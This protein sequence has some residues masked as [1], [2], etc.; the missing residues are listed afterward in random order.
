N[1]LRY[2]LSMQV[3]TLENWAKDREEEV[4]LLS[5]FPV[6]K[7]LDYEVMAARF[8]YFDHYYDQLN[9]IVYIDSDGYIR[10][11][12]GLDDTTVFYEPLNVSNNN[13]LKIAKEGE[14]SVYIVIEKLSNGEEAVI[15]ASPVETEEG[16]FNRVLMT[17][18]HIDRINEIICETI[19]GDTGK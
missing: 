9:S 17:A 2:S 8:N 18:V 16:D 12:T 15:F 14:R 7:E 3:T 11:D 19:Q 4:V 10:L 5:S 13:Y 1:S 6:T